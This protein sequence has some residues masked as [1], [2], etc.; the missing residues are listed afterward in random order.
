MAFGELIPDFVK[1]LKLSY[2]RWT[3]ESGEWPLPPIIEN[4]GSTIARLQRLYEARHLIAHELLPGAV[5]QEG[6][7]TELLT[8]ALDF[9]SACDWVVVDAL[10]GSVA[11][12]QT[13]MN[14]DAS[15]DLVKLISDMES[16]LAKI[17]SL[18]TVDSGKLQEARAA[19]AS[20]ADR[21]ATFEADWMEGGS[22]H[23]AAWASARA[24]LVEDRIHQLEANL[25]EAQRRLAL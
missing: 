3:E 6:E 20:F 1:R 14:I 15:D 18:P 22:M 17:Q 13:Q 4:Y 24:V 16:V 21:Q 19:W 8:A 11:R 5:V 23:P 2:P 7:V 12:T 25:Q 9:I 10:R